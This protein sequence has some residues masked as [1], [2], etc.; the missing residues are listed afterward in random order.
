MKKTNLKFKDDRKGLG[1]EDHDQLFEEN[2]W[3]SEQFA[4]LFRKAKADKPESLEEDQ[5]NR[6]KNRIHFSS[7]KDEIEEEDCKENY[8]IFHL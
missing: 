2:D 3:F 7:F 1:Y 8:F 4:A 6:I 5:E